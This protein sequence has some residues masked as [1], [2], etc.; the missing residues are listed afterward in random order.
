MRTDSLLS[1]NSFSIGAKSKLLAEEEF[2]DM[3]IN[4]LILYSDFSD[5]LGLVSFENY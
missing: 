2:F 4:D 3:S 5:G 1:F